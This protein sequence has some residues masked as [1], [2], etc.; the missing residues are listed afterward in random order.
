[1]RGELRLVLLG[2]PQFTLNDRRLTLDQLPVKGAALLAYLAVT[3]QEH[4][5]TALA[6]LLW[7]D[8]PEDRARANLRLSL[9]KLRQHL[10]DY[11]LTSRQSIAFNVDYLHWL[12]LA[13]FEAFLATSNLQSPISSLQSAL[14]LYR[15]DFLDDFQVAGAPEFEAWRLDQRERLRL[16]ALEA[17]D[18]LADLEQQAGHLLLAIETTRRLLVL[19][20]WQEEAHRRLMALLAQTGQRSAA[21]AQYETCR[22]L[23]AAELG[24]DPAPETTGLYHRIRHNN[25]QLTINSEQLTISNEQ[26]T[27][28]P[29]NSST[30]PPFQPS[31]LP[32]F[33]SLPPL[34][35]P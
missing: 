23:L 7:G 10:G 30:P 12:D 15:G 1:M 3:R 19:E 11:L 17:L 22:R 33:P 34:R 32:T 21:L 29:P 24:V 20:P 25:E 28:P 6:G 27:N 26:L 14:S 13:E 9:T 31:S 16:L 4:S 35:R 18:R 2:K 5:R 8:M